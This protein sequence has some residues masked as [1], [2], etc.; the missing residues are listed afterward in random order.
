MDQPPRIDLSA[1][2]RTPELF[3]SFPISIIIQDAT[4]QLIFANPVAQHILG[5][6]LEEMSNC[7]LGSDYRS[8]HHDWQISD[9]DG[10][11]LQAEDLPSLRCLRSGQALKDVIVG[12]QKPGTGARTWIKVSCTPLSQ[13]PGETPNLVLSVF[14]DLTERKVSDEIKAEA[15]EEL[16][17]AIDTIPAMLWSCDPEGMITHFNQSCL[18]YT[19]LT[20]EEVLGIGWMKSLHPDSVSI[21]Y[22]KWAEAS[23]NCSHYE[24]EL[25]LRSS[26]GQYRWFLSRANPILDAQDQVVQWYGVNVDIN[27]RKKTELALQQAQTDLA[28]AHAELEQRVAQRTLELSRTNAELQQSNRAKSEF[29][30]MMSHE[31]RTPLTA[32]MGLS[33]AL[34]EGVYGKLT[35]EQTARLEIIYESGEH[36]LKIINDILDLTKIETGRFDL[37]PGLVD[38]YALTQNCLLLIKESALKKQIQLS[39]TVESG[40]K[41]LLADEVRLKQ[42]LLNLLSNAVKF[43]PDGGTI[44]FEVTN[45]QGGDVIRFSVRDTGIGIPPD[46]IHLLFQPFVQVDAS[47]SRNYEG[48]GLGLALVRRLT[49]Q[50]GGSVGVESQLGLGSCFW[51]CIPFVLASPEAHSEMAMRPAHTANGNKGL[52][53]IAEDNPSNLGVIH[54]YLL[55]HA[56]RMV[57]AVNGNEVLVCAKEFRPDLILMDIQMPQMDGLEVIRILRRDTD[58]AHTPIIALTALVMPGDREKCLEAGADDYLEKP[59]SLRLLLSTLEKHLQPKHLP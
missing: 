15:D 10:V 37:R 9:G 25:Q 38:I 21:M 17:S 29:M 35:D 12:F 26:D 34:L 52:I 36:L 7:N 55:V 18:A 54:D 56:Y 3:N 13:T 49:E 2:F 8:F 44:D 4:G 58:F 20:Q 57:T 41:L 48:T 24:V 22:Q 16:R 30:A 1:Y 59:I 47:L 45:E 51:F 11:P 33:Q 42:M 32:V 46:K 23:T 53:L 28:V 27:D 31:L 43:T 50:M 19:G 14:E 39:L 40:I 5:L 6:S